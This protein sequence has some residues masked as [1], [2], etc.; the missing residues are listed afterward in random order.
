MKE[1]VAE[2]TRDVVWVLNVV[3][4]N[5]LEDVGSDVE[6]FVEMSVVLPPYSP[7]DESRASI[8]EATLVAAAA[9]KSVAA[10]QFWSLVF[11][12]VQGAKVT[13]AA[14]LQDVPLHV[15]EH[16]V[17]TAE[18]VVVQEEFEELVLL[19]GPEVV[20][21]LLEVWV[22]CE[23]DAD[24]S[25]GK[26]TRTGIV[27]PL[28][29]R[30]VYISLVV[31]PFIVFVEDVETGV[32]KVVIVGRTP[33]PPEAVVDVDI[34]EDC[35]S[36]LPVV[37]GGR[38][39]PDGGLG[40]E[41]VELLEGDELGGAELWRLELLL[42]GDE[43]DDAELWRLALLLLGDELDNGELWRLELLLEGDELDDA[44]LWR[45]ELLDGTELPEIE[46]LLLGDDNWEVVPFSVDELDDIE[47]W[48]AELLLGGDE[49]VGA[50]LPEFELLLGDDD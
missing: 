33:T 22:G 17:A 23:S 5:E 18:Q 10:T 15:A 49:P 35:E 8:P 47:L 43:P 21:I 28:E 7:Q 30:V 37:V 46:L 4:G 6:L 31:T 42:L 1:P 40:G 16:P 45:L 19:E 29:S 12:V 2:E 34:D 20:E 44:E 9:S 36:V 41:L 14:L 48:G 50:E 25:G 13:V 3:V 39:E 24:G 32:G 11:P 27:S 38:V 26:K